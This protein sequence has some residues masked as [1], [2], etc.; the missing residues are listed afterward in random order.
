MLAA[1]GSHLE[2]GGEIRV[3]DTRRVVGHDSCDVVHD[4]VDSRGLGD[5]ER[6][7]AAE[8]L[9]RVLGH[10]DSLHAEVGQERVAGSVVVEENDAPSG[11]KKSRVS[12][13]I[14][15]FLRVDDHDPVSRLERVKVEARRDDDPLRSKLGSRKIDELRA[16]FPVPPAPIEWGPPSR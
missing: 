9:G 12:F 5:R 7:V 4:R 11:A 14:E 13:D 10:G 3:T 6:W 1:R 16:P 8:R 2:D 15:R